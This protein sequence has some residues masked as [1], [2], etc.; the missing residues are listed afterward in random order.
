MSSKTRITRVAAYGIISNKDDILL[1][2][3]SAKLPHL[4]G[5]W[6]LPGGGLEFR[7]HPIDA[8]VRE[9]REETGL[10]VAPGDLAGVDSNSVDTPDADFHGIRILYHAEV[11]GG[12]LKNEQ[13][14]TT[15]L[16]QWCPRSSLS[17]LPMVELVNIGLAVLWPEGNSA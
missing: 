5:M 3:L 8:M 12:E 7:E 10:I 6:T 16:C 9:V 1:C 14:G 2:R 17:A 15:D 13:N 4:D 11:V